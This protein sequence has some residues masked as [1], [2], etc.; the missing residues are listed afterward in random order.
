[1]AW[2]TAEVTRVTRT[3]IGV[4][5]LPLPAVSGSQDGGGALAL[6]IAD[7]R[8]EMVEPPPLPPLAPG[9]A[10]VRTLEVGLCGTDR[11]LTH[12]DFAIAPGDSPFIVLGHELL[13]QVEEVPQGADAVRPGDHVVAAIRRGC[14][15]CQPCAANRADFCATGEFLEHGIRRLHGF[16]RPLSDVDVDSLV[17]VP[18]ELLSVAVFAEPLAVVE[19]TL[20]QVEAAR[21]RLP[22]IS[23]GQPWRALVAGAGSVGLLTAILLRARGHEVTVLDRRPRTDIQVK[24]VLE[25]GSTYASDGVESLPEASFDVVVEATGD[26]G[27]AFELPRVLATNGVLCW[28]GLATVPSPA[29][30]D[31]SGFTLRSIQHQHVMLGAVNAAPV[32]IRQAVA[33]LHHLAAIEGFQAAIRRARPSAYETAL[34]P[35]SVTVKGT[36]DYRPGDAAGGQQ[37]RPE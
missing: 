26:G 14:G 29:M 20:E 19:K 8:L 13:G 5:K 21:A 32:H 9:R 2:M 1:M 11:E 10:L 17:V 18:S 22:C 37:D 31:R 28:L 6:F 34:N 15:R 23:R 35:S 36:L 4:R 27:L 16:A 33:D 12:G 7:R 3:F 25:S 30:V 24:L